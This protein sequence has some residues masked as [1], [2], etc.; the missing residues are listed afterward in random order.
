ME[1]D[2]RVF[3]REPR[4][5]QGWLEVGCLLGSRRALS[6]D[7]GGR[8]LAILRVAAQPLQPH[9]A[10]G[11]S[12]VVGGVGRR[13]T[14]GP[15]PRDERPVTGFLALVDGRVLGDL[16]RAGRCRG[17]GAL[18]E[19]LG[20]RGSVRR[21]G[22]GGGVAEA[23]RGARVLLGVRSFGASRRWQVAGCRGG[24]LQTPAR[25]GPPPEVHLLGEPT[26]IAG[27]TCRVVPDSGLSRRGRHRFGQAAL[28]AA[29]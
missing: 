11:L 15:R 4:E 14:E 2:A 19:R 18:R 16:P 1:G 7:M 23:C 3:P 22:R 6:S 10:L 25:R 9:H 17:G 26:C 21:L 28:A 24:R 8:V 12:A 5:R 13:C 29:A 20:G 27:G